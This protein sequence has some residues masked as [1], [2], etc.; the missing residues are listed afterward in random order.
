MRVVIPTVDNFCGQR[1]LSRGDSSWVVH[2]GET[3]TSVAG[4]LHRSDPPRDPHHQPDLSQEPADGL[5][6]SSTG[7][8]RRSSRLRSAPTPPGLAWATAHRNYPNEDDISPLF[9]RKA[10]ARRHQGHSLAKRGML[11]DTAYQ[12][13]HDEVMLDGNSRLNLATFVGTW[14]EPYAQ[15]L[16]AD[17]VD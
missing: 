11:A 10:E 13:I 17:A 16:Y 3:R 5:W 9:S 7:P 4:Q 2:L 8:T 1:A 15:R 6:I 12:V 14:M